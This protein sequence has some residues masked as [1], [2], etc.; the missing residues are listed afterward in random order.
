MIFLIL[1]KLTEIYFS[2]TNSTKKIVNRITEN[3]NVNETRTIDITKPEVRNNKEITFADN[4]LIIIGV[5]VYS[6]KAPNFILGYLKQLI[7]NNNLVVL[8]SSFGNINEGVAL[9]QMKNI[10][11]NN[12]F[13]VIGAAAFVSQHSFFLEDMR[14]AEGRPDK[15]DFTKIDNFSERLKAKIESAE[16]LKYF[17][18]ITI[19]QTSNLA[20][21]YPKNYEKP[22][23]S[24]VKMLVK[25]PYRDKEKCSNCLKCV[26]ACPVQAINRENLKVN[27]DICIR[28][29]KCVDL[30]PSNAR[31]KDF[32]LKK[33][34][35]YSF[36]KLGR[37]R[38]EPS[39]YL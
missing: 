34:F 37:D 13:T 39:F 4:E 9:Q 30:C 28:C 12:N 38:K 24:E 23:V 35:K 1:E 21:T 2:P 8:I 18:N 5:P 32:N 11:I 22:N 26:D 25:V 3:L 29:Y 6:G 33:L 31:Q 36:N 7:G 16:D 14:I 20:K 17:K 15:E 19:N 10:L 27:N